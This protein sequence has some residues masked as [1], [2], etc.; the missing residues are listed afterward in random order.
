MN[1][2]RQGL[3][4]VGLTG[5]TAALAVGGE[6]SPGTDQASTEE[7]NGTIWVEVADLST[8][9]AYLGG[10]GTTTAGIVMGGNT[11]SVSAATEEWSGSSVTT[12]VLTD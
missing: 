9:R 1:A 5:N 11:G 7:W 12:K 6:T 10:A 3:V 4:G 8:A 2:G